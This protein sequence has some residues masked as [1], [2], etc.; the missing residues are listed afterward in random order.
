KHAPHTAAHVSSDT[1]FHPY[2]REQAAYPAPWLRDH[3]FWPAVGRID[4]PFGDRNLHCTCPSVEEMT[5]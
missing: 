3:K 1:W 2:T 5:G 4:N